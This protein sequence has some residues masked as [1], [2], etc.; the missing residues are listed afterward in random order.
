ML[1]YDLLI[2]KMA[3]ESE[4]SAVVLEKAPAEAETETKALKLLIAVLKD[5]HN[6]L[7]GNSCKEK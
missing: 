6:N 3:V 4:W 5:V 2:N 7:G 1:S